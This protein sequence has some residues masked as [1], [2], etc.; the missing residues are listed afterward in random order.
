M[1]RRV[2]LPLLLALVAAGAAWMAVRSDEAAAEVPA[3][4]VEP[5][6]GVVTP[7]LSARRVPEFLQT[8]A[9]DQ[10]LATS[11]DLRIAEVPADACLVVTEDGRTILERNAAT[12]LTPASLQ[13]IVTAE[14]ALT[15][16]GPDHRYRTTV[17]T[18]GE[19]V[20]GVVEGDVWFV[21]GGDPALETADYAAR[22]DPPRPS[23][24]LEA[25]ADAVVAAGIREIRGDVVGDESR[26]DAV[27]YV[28]SWPARFASPQNQTGPLSALSVN[29]GFTSF[30]ADPAATSAARPAA[31]PPVHAAGILVG[32]LEE[33]GVVVTGG[34]ASGVAPVEATRELGAIESAPLLDILDAMLVY[35]DN[36]TAELVLKELAP[37]T[38]G[39]RSTV[40]GA[41]SAAAV[42]TEAGYPTAGVVVV[43][44]SGLDAG[45]RLTCD[46]LADVL[47]R[48]GPDSRLAEGFPVAG[49]P[50][51]LETRFEG[52]PA[53]GRIRAKT[54]SLLFVTSL[55]G[56][57]DAQDGRILTFAYIANRDPLPEDAVV[58]TVPLGTDLVAYPPGPA[59]DLL[60]PEPV[61]GAVAP[62]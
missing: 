45:N 12:P 29:D 33:R 31:D 54:G 56:F 5:G 16:L 39:Q 55:A 10:L 26:Y 42:L 6:P 7:V 58:F 48:E 23:T 30:P 8:P 62:G 40:A 61:P 47:D 57:A 51:T 14:A 4:T 43:D 32:L 41:A 22:Y 24:S 28:P 19:P 36:T 34:A 46:L 21:G 38:A 25:L 17:V 11:L 59:I 35:S 52:T 15:L 50:G 18:A 1:L 2:L 49:E 20:D 60:D 53:D 3:R 44:G 37:A 27:R 13:K 9:A